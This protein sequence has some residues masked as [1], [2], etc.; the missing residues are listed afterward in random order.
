VAPPVINLAQK[1]EQFSEQWTPKVIAQLGEYQ[2]KLAKLDGEFVWH[3]H[4]DTAEGFLVLNGL[5]Q[6]DFRDQSVTLHAG[7]LCIVPPGVEH[8]PVASAEC[9]VL[10]LVREGT[11]NTGDSPE[12]SLT[13]DS[14]QWI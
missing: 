7:E 1:L 5:L 10:L 11:V 4:P 9:H 12:N 3:S 13:N 2:F 8:K 14:S 6:I